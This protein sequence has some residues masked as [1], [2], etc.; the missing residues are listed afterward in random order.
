MWY[1]FPIMNEEDYT[2]LG[3]DQLQELSIET[4]LTVR[5]GR[6]VPFLALQWPCACSRG[7]VPTRALSA[8]RRTHWLRFC[9]RTSTCFLCARRASILVDGTW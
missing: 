4:R 8:C 9:V 1:P 6:V 7:P 5:I 2:Y 3:P